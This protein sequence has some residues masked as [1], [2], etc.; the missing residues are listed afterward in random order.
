MLYHEFSC[1]VIAIRELKTSLLGLLSRPMLAN[2]N[3]TIGLVIPAVN[4]LITIFSILKG[5]F[6]MTISI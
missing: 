1:T 5:Y 2:H 4:Y 3:M 6:K